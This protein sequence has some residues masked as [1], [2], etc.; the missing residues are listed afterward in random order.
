MPLNE[1]TSFHL[2]VQKLDKPELV[3]YDRIMRRYG[4]GCYL[5]EAEEFG[6]HWKI[7]FGVYVP[8]KI[9]DEKN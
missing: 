6:D 1:K 8:S 9:V 4:T 5:H 3:A 2:R 7:P